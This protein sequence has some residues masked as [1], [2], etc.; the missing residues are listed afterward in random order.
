M[1]HARLS[2]GWTAWVTRKKSRACE[3]NLRNSL[4]EASQ[5]NGVE[6]AQNKSH[7]KELVALENEAAALKNAGKVRAALE[8]LEEAIKLDKRW[9]HFRCKAQWKF[10]TCD[11]GGAEQAIDYGLGFCEPNQFW[12]LWWKAEFLFRIRLKVQD[13]TN[14]LLRAERTLYDESS[15]VE[16][17]YL[18][19]PDPLKWPAMVDLQGTERTNLKMALVSLRSEIQSMGKSLVL[20]N[21][22]T[23]MEKNIGSE[24]V[25]TIELLGVFAAILAFIFSGV[26]I[27][28]TLPLFE[29]LLL[30]AGMAL[31]M[32]IFFLGVHLVIY[33][34]ARTRLLIAILV[35]L[36]VLFIALPTY[37]RFLEGEDHDIQRPAVAKGEPNEV[38]KTV[39]HPA[40]RAF[41][42]QG[43]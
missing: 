4:M 38:E 21:K 11:Y 34:K 1:E 2:S 20:F 17:D 18:N 32:S 6:G 27:L 19:V 31:L 25:R 12:L 39:S 42:Q 9:Y 13:A 23:E 15:P 28:T 26:H 35:I 24:R 10:E 29:A 36:T 7:T 43:P 22:I 37:A 33:P 41:P 16:I 30:Q 40:I 3:Y 14:E 8:K 5:T